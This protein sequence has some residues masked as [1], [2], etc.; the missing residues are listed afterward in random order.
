MPDLAIINILAD[1][2]SEVELREL[3]LVLYKPSTSF[4]DVICQR[5]VDHY[6]EAATDLFCGDVRNHV[7]RNCFLP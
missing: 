6:P 5:Y 2:L 3:I 1:K 7:I 4:Y